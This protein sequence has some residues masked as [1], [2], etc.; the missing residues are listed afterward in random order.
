MRWWGWGDDEHAGVL[1]APA[2]RLLRDEL[3]IGGEV[4]GPVALDEVELPEPRLSDS[5]LD[6]L[7]GA[8][9]L[10]VDREARVLHAAGKGYIDLVRLR[11][12]RPEGAPDAVALPTTPEEVGAVLEACTAERVAV[13]PFGGG[14]SVVGGVS[15]V[16][17]GF[18]RVLSLDL[19]GLH[20]LVRVDERSLTVTVEGG[21]GAL[22][23]EAA[24]GARGLTLGHFPQSFEYVTIGGCVAT[25]SAGQASTGFGRIDEL[26]V[27]LRCR[28]P[29]GELA[30][31]VVPASAA[32]PDLRELIVGSEGALGVITEATLRV[33][34]RAPSERY[35]AWMMP[36]FAAGVEALRALEQAGAAPDVTRLSDP[37]ETRL[38]LAMSGAA[39]GRRGQLLGGYLRLRR[40]GGGACLA[41]LGWA[42]DEGAIGA[43]RVRAV[44]V[45]RRE[46]G[47]GLGAAPGRAW[48]RSRYHGP[49][50]RDHLLDRGVLAET[51]ETATTWSNLFALYVAVGDALRDALGARGT[52][53]LVGCHISHLYSAGASLYFTFLARQ[54]RGAEAEQWEAAKRAASEAIVAAGGTIT[55]H[56]A[57]GRDHVDYLEA[58]DGALGLQAL[59]AVKEELDPAGIMNPGK[60]LASAGHVARS[61]SP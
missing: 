15:P 49:Y 61:G 45:M 22:E 50:L 18:E 23:L 2:Q 3:G 43:R 6:R 32:G 58:E 16:A 20:R 19:G 27:G 38:S 35:E 39:E 59:R 31:P 12:G 14:T 36:S 25:R 47:A 48:E 56:H 53:P 44:E 13:V 4:R 24:L 1:D 41:I 28:A 10:R 29:A 7:R 26:V 30:L 51:L 54:E 42:G 11:A 52:P 17:A 34:R 46:G 33:R 8:C 60:L 5:V 21:L 9:E 55:H 40:V 57:I 37:E